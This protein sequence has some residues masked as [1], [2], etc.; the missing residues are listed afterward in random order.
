[1]HQANQVYSRIDIS[2]GAT[3]HAASIQTRIRK[4]SALAVSGALLAAIAGTKKSMSAER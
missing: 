4:A 2:D 1:M 3:F